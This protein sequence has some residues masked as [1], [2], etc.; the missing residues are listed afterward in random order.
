MFDNANTG[1]TP[2]SAGVLAV[3]YSYSST[4]S[5]GQ[6]TAFD[7]IIRNSGFSTGSAS[8][9]S[10][11]C[12]PSSSQI[13]LE[14]VLLHELGHAL[15]LGHINDGSQGA[16]PNNNPGKLMH[17]AVEFSVKRVT[18]DGSAYYGAL[19]IC[20]PQSSNFSTCT[21]TSEMTQLSYTTVTNDN[22][23]SNF[24]ATATNIGTVI[25]FNL[26]YATSNS[27]N[28]PQFT[29]I[30]CTGLGT[31]VT[32][33]QFY[34]IKTLNSGSLSIS[35]SGYAT[36]PSGL[37]SCSSNGVE[38]SLYAVSSCPDGGNFPMPIAC[39]TF[40][41]NGNLTN[42]TGLLANTDY[43]LVAD[44]ISNTKAVFNLTFNGSALPI[45]LSSFTG[46][47]FNGYNELK[48]IAEV[49]SE[50]SKIIIE[51][52]IDGIK[53]EPVGTIAGN[54][55]LKANN[56]FNDYAPSIGNNYYR[57]VV[58]F[59]SGEKEYSK[60]V[61]LKRKDKLLISI[62][63]N[64]AKGL[65]NVQVSSENNGNYMIEVYNL[66]GQKVISNK[67][68][69]NNNT[70]NSRLNVSNLANGIYQV[71]I[72]DNQKNRLTSKSLVVEN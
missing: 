5:V 58:V 30:K 8:F 64:P 43:L 56:S 39:R 32:N 6:K 25:P 18:P 22:C 28:D 45:K 70:N 34:P 48:W 42:I 54:D 60:V 69:L 21:Y 7:V 23:P 53:F 46:E 9:T 57:L 3:C 16:N 24:Q 52:S 38:L 55:V 66:N 63:P 26:V 68:T 33:T 13:D 1:T 51:K 31:S 72:F 2:L 47:I 35:V 50:I 14:T 36:T 19:Y 59:K 17:F 71:V 41:A 44:G 49:N 15:S 29:E 61:V 65:A 4:C 37:N 27:L 40:T 20:N 11:P 67:I 10:G 12:A 62:N